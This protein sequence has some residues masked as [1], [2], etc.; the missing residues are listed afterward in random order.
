VVD[1]LANDDGHALSIA[2][3]IVANLNWQKPEQLV[4]TP[5][6]EPRYDPREL[7]GVL[8]TDTRKPYD[9]REVIA[10]IVDD[11]AFDEWKARYG[12]TL[13]T[14]FARIHGMP[15][16]IIANNGILF[17]ESA[18][19]A[20]HFIELCC[21]RKI[22]LL[23]LQNISGFMVG[24]KYENEGIARNGAKM[25]TAVACA[26]VPKFTI[27]IGGSFGAGNYGMC[28]RAY[29][30][31]FLWMW[32]NARISVMGGEQAASVL[33]TVKRDGIESRGGAWSA[34]EEAAFK[35]PLRTQYE[36]EGHPYYATARLWDDG[37][38]DPADTRRV[39]ALAMSA[40][41]NAPIAE[42]RFGV[43]RM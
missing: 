42:T 40:S 5:P 29:S 14:G 21:Q 2:R 23:F 22:P 17:S 39:L 11:S 30:P 9:V 12:T 26:Q 32:P 27:I 37:I 33:A 6:I 35:E 8:P 25:V 15:I 34:E 13:V 24:R 16:G 7:Y 41:L 19:K 18:L 10:R 43:F 3:G 20:A 38:I 1:W 36:R 28:G 31:R 4:R